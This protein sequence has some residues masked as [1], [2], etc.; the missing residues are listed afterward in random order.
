[1]AGTA[2]GGKK[3]AAKNLAKDPDFYKKIGARGG[4]NGNT[5]GFAYK[6]PCNCSLIKDKNHLKARCAGKIG[7]LISRRPAKA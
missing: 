6:K 4:A 7:G 2:I 3:S 5:G 1:M